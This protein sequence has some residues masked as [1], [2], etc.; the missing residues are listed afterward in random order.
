M[1]HP[2]VCMIDAHVHIINV[3]IINPSYKGITHFAR[4]M[5]LC[6]NILKD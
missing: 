2:C 6:F 1:L 3:H 4:L 5:H